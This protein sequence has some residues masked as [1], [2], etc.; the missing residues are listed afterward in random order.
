MKKSILLILILMTLIACNKLYKTDN[1]NQFSNWQLIFK[2]DKNGNSI[3]G[4]K[5][6]LINAVRN[7]N[8]IRVGWSSQRINDTTK[9]VEHFAAAKF[10][11]IS[12]GKEVFAQIDPIIGQRPDLD[13]DTLS[14]NF[15]ESFR[16]SILVG[17]NGFS[18]RLN[19][20]TFK[21]SVVS[22]LNRV[23]EVSWFVEYRNNSKSH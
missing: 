22:H 21:D 23:T 16:W 11:T 20:D 6:K 1:E 5:E 4:E 13:S 2:N 14:I 10:L 12:N 15:R 3:F 18:D 7:G 17:T 9:S 8:S 19:I